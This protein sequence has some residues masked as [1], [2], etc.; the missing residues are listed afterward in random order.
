MRKIGVEERRARLGLRHQLARPAASVEAVADG[1]VGLHSS[2]PATV[3]LSAWARVDDFV[4]ADIEDA[5]Y[6]RRSLVRMLGSSP[7][8]SFAISGVLRTADR[9]SYIRNAGS[10]PTISSSQ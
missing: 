6:E 5:L 8:T 1:V 9:R 4:P 7:A 2:D 3:F 10:C